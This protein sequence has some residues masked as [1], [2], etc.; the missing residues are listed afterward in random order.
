M[1]ALVILL[2]SLTLVPRAQAGSRL[3]VDDLGLDLCTTYFWR[4]FEIVDH[5][6]LQPTASTSLTETPLSVAFWGSVVLGDH[7]N[8]DATDEL[9]V[10]L[11]AA[12]DFALGERTVSAEAG[13]VLYNFPEAPKG[14][15]RSAEV[16]ASLSPDLAL[17][18]TV[19]YFYD[20][21]QWDASY[22]SLALAPE[23]TL[24]DDSSFAIT[25]SIGFGDT[26]QPFGFQD[27]TCAASTSF[28]WKGLDWVPTLG[29]TRA[30]RNVNAD[31]GGVWGTIGLRFPR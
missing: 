5:P 19:S 10:T 3:E 18:P 13:S 30:S 4:G 22:V 26:D 21:D 12:H 11:S 24:H 1:K 29:V 8:H 31:R 25:P 27:L 9:D 2:L 7:N 6:A 14:T 28:S 16:F 20:F 17:A 15:R 23:F